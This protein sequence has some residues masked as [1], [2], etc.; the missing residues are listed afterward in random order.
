MA[1]HALRNDADRGGHWISHQ[2]RST[3]SNRNGS[4]RKFGEAGADTVDE[5]VARQLPLAFGL[6]AHFGWGRRPRLQK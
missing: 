6:A 5:C 1:A 3:R 2:A 4:A